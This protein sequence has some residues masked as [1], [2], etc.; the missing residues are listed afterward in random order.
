MKKPLT[1]SLKRTR[2][3]QLIDTLD[4]R[5]YSEEDPHREQIMREQIDV[6]TEILRGTK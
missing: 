4:A 1:L 2:I 5:A 6:L 3:R